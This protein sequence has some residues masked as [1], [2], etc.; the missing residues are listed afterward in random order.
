MLNF[1]LRRLPARVAVLWLAVVLAG[2]GLVFPDNMQRFT[3]ADAA[4]ASADPRATQAGLDVLAAGGNAFDAAV[5]VAATLG[6]VEPSSSGFGGGGFFLLF[7]AECGCYH[8]IDARETAPAAATPA[9]YLDQAG[10]PVRGLTVSGPLAAGIPGEPAGMAYLAENF[11]SKPLAELL[12]P[13]IYHAENGF[14]MSPRALLGLRFRKNTVSRWPAMAEIFLPG[15]E[16]PAVGYVVKQPELA[17]T[18]RRF[19]AG[20]HDGFY[21]GETARRLVAGVQ[22]AGGNW[23]LEDLANYQVVE[24]EPLVTNYRGMQVVS[25]PLPS[26]GGIVM[27]QVFNFL[28]AYSEEQLSGPQGQHL[29]I[30]ALRRAY[31]DRALYMGDSDFVDV[32]VERLVSREYMDAQRADVSLTRATPS[33]SLQG[34]AEDGSAGDQTTHFSVLDSDG[35]RVAGTITINTWYGSAFMPPGTGVILNNEMDDFSIKPGVPNEFELVGAAANAVAPGKR[36]LSSMSPT[37]LESDRGV[38][39]VG[40]PGGSRIITMVLRA[41]LAWLDG[42]TAEQMVSL[43]RFHHQYLPDSVSYESGAFTADEI[44][45]L[46]AMGHSLKE[47]QRPF[48]NM[49]V[50]TWDIGPNRVE[51]ASD[52]RG[53]GEGRVY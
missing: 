27:A 35:N 33:A 48:G 5:A 47:V 39:V 29:L 6:V 25:A 46:E 15:G 9:T 52:P 32:P 37:F 51:S 31:R 42:A 34:V 8:F 24:R 12:Q 23:T 20:G 2:C 49:N 4:V 7:R 44:A 43:K 14:P 41:A 36:P 11:G 50:V 17:D 45:A 3:P 16:L 19:A 26:S 18:I 22:A 53:E 21:K 13:A 28:S 1:K 30:E 40:T 10:N 38:A